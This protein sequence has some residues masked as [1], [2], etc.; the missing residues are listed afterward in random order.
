MSYGYSLV[1]GT[2]APKAIQNTPVEIWQEIIEHILYDP[3]AFITDPYYPGCNLHTAYNE[4][5]DRKRLRKLEAQRGTLRLVSRSWKDLADLHPWRYFQ[6]LHCEDLSQQLAGALSARRLDFHFLCPGSDHLPGSQDYDVCTACAQNRAGR[7]L[8]F[9]HQNAELCSA[10]FEQATIVH[11]QERTELDCVIQDAP[12]Q[13][14]FPRLRA[15]SVGEYKVPGKHLLGVSTNLMFL[16]LRLAPG[17]HDE[18]YEIP[19]RFPAL[20]TLCLE[21]E[22]E[23]DFDPLVQWKMPLLAHVELKVPFVERYDRRDTFFTQLGKNL[24][25]FSIHTYA[26]QHLSPETYWMWMP[27]LEYL[28][29]DRLSSK[30]AFSPPPPDYSLR[31]FALMEE[32][33]RYTAFAR[34][35]SGYIAERWKTLSTIADCHSWEDLTKWLK[36]TMPDNL[37]NLEKP[38]AS[39]DHEHRGFHCW[40]CIHLLLWKCKQN[41]LRYED[42]TGRTWAEYFQ[43]AGVQW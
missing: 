36:A 18:K 35:N 34:K 41:G 8:H 40:E 14:L 11:I 6:P 33:I 4:W 30:W 24:I 10:T 20:R 15:L 23:E 9:E 1:G 31:T 42:R 25:R 26:R 32:D 28:S 38:A 37:P 3:I 13:P 5:T 12:I 21:V 19:L 29:V 22:D 16:S 39:Y 43:A 27:K 17:H 2:K 7:R